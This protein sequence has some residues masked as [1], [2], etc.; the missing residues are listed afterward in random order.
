M[1]QKKKTEKNCFSRTYNKQQKKNTTNF[2]TP[3]IRDTNGFTLYSTKKNI[4]SFLEWKVVS[5]WGVSWTPIVENMYA[6]RRENSRK[7]HAHAHYKKNVFVVRK[8]KN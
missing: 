3:I 5:L 6:P 4:I 8:I 2:L 7:L 1:R